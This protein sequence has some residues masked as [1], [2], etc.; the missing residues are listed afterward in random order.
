[1]DKREIF[2]SEEAFGL[3]LE[4]CKKVSFICGTEINAKSFFSRALALAICQCINDILAFDDEP[5][6]YIDQAG[7]VKII[8]IDD[9]LRCVL[10]CVQLFAA[11]SWT[12]AR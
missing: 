12:A 6:Q 8:E 7:H 4:L 11:T 9:D 2:I 3:F 5:F 1:M 10:S